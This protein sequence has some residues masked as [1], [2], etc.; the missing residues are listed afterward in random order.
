MYTLPKVKL[1]Q[2]ES[3][4][5]VQEGNNTLIIHHHPIHQQKN[6]RWL[7]EGDG[8]D[9]H[10][11]CWGAKL[12]GSV[13]WMS[14]CK[15]SKLRVMGLK[16]KSAPQAPWGYINKKG[17]NYSFLSNLCWADPLS[18]S[19]AGYLALNTQSRNQAGDCLSPWL[20]QHLEGKKCTM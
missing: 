11:R 1:C 14:E 20:Q 19:G 16:V 2:S 12:R 17:K 10:P 7:S 9:G 13:F 18:C 3:Q 15:D 4:N 5:Q 6:M 8:G